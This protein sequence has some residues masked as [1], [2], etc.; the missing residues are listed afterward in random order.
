MP[1]E[2]EMVLVGAAI[3]GSCGA[4]VYP[5]LQTAA[6]EMGSL[7]QAVWPQAENRDYFDRKYKVFSQ[8]IDDQK[9]YKDLMEN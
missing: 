8:M 4:K 7:S 9:R 6:K 1:N 2:T 5:D 3:L